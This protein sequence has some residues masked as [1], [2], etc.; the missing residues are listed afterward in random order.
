MKYPI[1]YIYPFLFLALFSISTT[2]IHADVRL[3][4]EELSEQIPLSPPHPASAHIEYEYDD[5][6]FSGV[7]NDPLFFQFVIYSPHYFSSGQIYLMCY[8]T[9]LGGLWLQQHTFEFN[10]YTKNALNSGGF[11]VF[12]TTTSSAVVGMSYCNDTYPVKVAFS[13][14]DYYSETNRVARALGGDDVPYFVIADSANELPD[15][16][17]LVVEITDNIIGHQIWESSSSTIYKISGDITV[18]NSATLDLKPGTIVK[19]DTGTSSNLTIEG[20]LYATGEPNSGGELK[21]IFFTSLKDDLIGGDTNGD[22]TSTSP[23]AGDWGGIKVSAGG[24]AYIKESVIRY[25]GGDDSAALLHNNGG[26]LDMASSTVV[27]GTDYGI[28]NSAGTTTA[29]TVDL[30]FNDYGLYLDSGSVSITAS[31]TIHDN[32]IYGIQNNTSNTINAEGNWWNVSTGPYHSGSNPS[33][34]GD[35]VSNY[36]DFTPWVSNIHF[37]INERLDCSSLHDCNSVVN[38]LIVSTSTSKYRSQL[39][40]AT[41]TWNA[42]GSVNIL[43]ATS[44]YATLYIFDVYRDDVAWKGGLDFQSPLPDYLGLNTYYLDS[45]SNNEIINTITHELGHALGLDHSFTGNVMYSYQSSQTTL[46][47][48]DENDYYYSWP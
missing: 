22:A 46:G 15:P 41:S 16:G 39:D 24:E 10:T 25:G 38:S 19:F 40:S 45:D 26:R 6:D 43:S 21:Q 4:H 1:H 37:V 23:S 5:F 29:T 3:S 27:Y 35:A 28:K 9:S 11:H 47:P 17:Q 12:S 36:V 34:E 33:G 13:N 48:Q 20:I 42:L 30:A 44:S 2:P 8:S 32:S 31:S 7:S 14:V 18:E